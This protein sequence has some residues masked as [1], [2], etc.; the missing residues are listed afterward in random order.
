MEGRTESA[1]NQTLVAFAFVDPNESD[2]QVDGVRL[3]RCAYN[4]LGAF[5]D[6]F[7]ESSPERGLL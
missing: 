5:I 6:G 4:L 7:P 3:R 1:L 2:Y